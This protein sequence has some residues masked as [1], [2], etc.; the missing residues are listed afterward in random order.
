MIEALLPHKG[1]GGGLK[2][3]S[4]PWGVER[5]TSIYL[6][7]EPMMTEKSLLASLEAAAAALGLPSPHDGRKSLARN[8][9]GKKWKTRQP[10][11]L[12][13][14]AWHQ[15]L[16]WGSI[17]A[18][19]KYHTGKDSHLAKG[20]VESLGYTLAIRRNG[21]I[22][23]G[24]DLDRAPWSQG[25][26]GRPGDE[27]AEFLSVMF[28]G[29]FHGEGVTDPSAGE[30][31]DAQMLAG[32][33]LWRICRRAWGWAE[34]GLCGHFLFGK[35]SCPGSTLETLVNAVRSN[36]PATPAYDFATVAG[37]QRALKDLGFLKA[38]A[39]GIWGPAS[40]G[41]L[42]AFQVKAGLAADGVWGPNT[43]AAVRKA[44]GRK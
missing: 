18:V 27:N 7:L 35:P 43:E 10:K 24:N 40:K 33:A 17:E 30:P 15:E 16:G 38:D 3:I 39:D 11:D 12:L 42:T 20:G 28:E 44:L 41:A 4:P 13:G 31:N 9:A 6:V 2:K 36:L 22:V 26:A 25:Y 37:R 1:Y 8:P 14:M 23:L 34:D 32:L 5:A 21:Q 29:L 19:A